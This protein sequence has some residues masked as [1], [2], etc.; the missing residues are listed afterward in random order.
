M[1]KYDIYNKGNNELF[2]RIAQNENID[3]LIARLLVNRDVKEECVNAYLNPSQEDLNDPHLL[4]DVD[5]ASDI[6][7]AAINDNKRIR[8]IGDYDIDGVMSTF[9]LLDALEKLGA[10]VDYTIPHRIEDGYGLN[11]NIISN[12]IDDEVNLIITCDN[13]IAALEEIQMARDA[14]IDVIV[15]DHHEVLYSIEQD[16]RTEKLP[17]ANAVVNPKRMD[18]NYPFKK[19]CGAAVA[20]K[21]VLVL[22]EKCN[23]NSGMDYIENVA[24]ATIGDVMELV[25]ENRTIVKLG[26]D[27]LSRTSNLGMKALLAEKGITEKVSSYHVGFV[28][29]PCVNASGRLE[30]ATKSLELLRCKDIDAAIKIARELASLNEKRKDLTE[31]A[32]MKAFDLVEEK[33]TN[34][35]VLVIYVP[36][37]HE[38]IAGIVAGK[39]REKYCKPT[40]MLA[41]GE[42]CIKGSGRSI[43]AFN[44]FEALHEV[45][46]LFVKYGGHPLAAGLSILPENV[47]ELRERLNK[48]SHLTPEDLVEKCTI[49][50]T[51]NFG[52]ITEELIEELQRLEPFGNGN[53]KPVFAIRN[54]NILKISPMG[55]EGQFMRMTVS[56][57]ATRMTALFFG[58]SNELK[59]RMIDKWGEGVVSD[60]HRGRNVNANVN[61]IYYPQINE[62]RNTRSLQIVVSDVLL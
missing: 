62:F 48:N 33:Y 11:K 47:D 51:M 27:A 35:N 14:S 12:A 20:W 37:M 15:T 9:I 60:L 55:K 26:L 6:V 59:S 24:F 30:S 17:N 43:P 49:D 40:I 53:K 52:Y 50:V 19:L 21:L 8:I 4:A 18:C 31:Q 42:G 58:D 3:P 1:V 39:V 46:E 10:N 57:E 61:L 2:S 44:M 45:D 13:G 22:F 29:G 34:D 25:D 54:V 7:L 56:D 32:K 28:L 5:V 41:D 36:G 38:S 16:V 23:I